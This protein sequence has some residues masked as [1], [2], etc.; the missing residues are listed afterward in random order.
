MFLCR[1]VACAFGCPQ[2]P[3]RALA[4][5]SAIVDWRDADDVS[6]VGGAE[7]VEYDGL[8][9]RPRNGGLRAADLALIRGLVRPDFEPKL[10]QG[11]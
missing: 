4:I 10:I 9:Y 6:Q 1:R 5:S 7:S 8:G 2:D 3:A 11:N